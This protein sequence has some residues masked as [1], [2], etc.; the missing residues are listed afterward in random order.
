MLHAV[1]EHA[2]RND[3]RVRKS[4]EDLLQKTKKHLGKDA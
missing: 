3:S 4:F 1:T 2:I